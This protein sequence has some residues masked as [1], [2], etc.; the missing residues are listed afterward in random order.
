[1]RMFGATLVDKIPICGPIMSNPP[2]LAA[3]KFV[4]V[5]SAFCW[6]SL[7]LALQYKL[8]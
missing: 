4:L 6:N 2:F 1:M 7:V 3:V 5:E 8:K